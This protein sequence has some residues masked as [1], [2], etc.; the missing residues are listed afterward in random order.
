MSSLPYCKTNYGRFQEIK[1]MKTKTFKTSEQL[2]ESGKNNGFITQDD[3][4][5][6]FPE[7]EKHLAKLDEL[8]DKLIRNKIDIFETTALEEEEKTQ[9]AIT[10]LEKELALL[11]HLSEGQSLDPVRTYL[12][13]IGRIPLLKFEQEINF[14]QRIE[15][16]DMRA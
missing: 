12:R 11:S 2:F 9:K 14:A 7:P 13:E 4:L 3:I 5:M 10:E 8:Y 1:S 15:K 6:L 16:G